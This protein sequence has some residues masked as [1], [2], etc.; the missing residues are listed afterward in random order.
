[1]V[2]CLVFAGTALVARAGAQNA[3]GAPSSPQSDAVNARLQRLKEQADRNPGTRSF[4]YD[5]VQALEEAGREAELLALRPRLDLVSAPATVLAR[6]ARA[7]SSAKQF[8]LA[9]ELFE[10]ALGKAPDR[11]DL[12][13]GLA[14]ALV[15]AGRPADAQARLET[16]P[17]LLQKHVALLDAYAEALRARRE[18]AQALL[19]Y[20]RILVLE[21]AN[22]EAQ[23]NR[24]FT[25]AQLGAPHRAVELAEQSPG[26]LTDAEFAQLRGDRAAVAA[27]WGMAADQNAPARFA[28]TDAALEQNAQLLSATEGAQ[29]RRLQLDR[30]V[31]L[32][33][34]YRMREA[35]DLYD[36]VVAEAGDIPSYVQVAA[37]DACLYLEKPERARDLYKAAIA[38]GSADIG[39]QLGLFYAYNDTEEHQAAMEQIERVVRETPTRVRAYS[40]LTEGDNPDY[41][42]AVATAGAARGYQDRLN[43]AQIQL[44]AFRNQAPWNME[45]RERLAGVY[46]ARGWPRRAELEYQWILAAETRNRAARVGRAHM[47][48]ERRDWRPA[49]SEALALD[50]EY[51]EDRQVQR[52]ATLWRI[53]E[54]REL[55]IEAGTGDSSGSA[56]PLG[57]REH[58]VESWL[59]SSPVRY[60]WRAFL[61]HYDAQATFP[62][63]RG[64]W[65]RIGA[66]A[67][68]RLRDWRA[69]AEVSTGYGGDEGI[70]LTL[71]GDWSM[72]DYWNFEAETE[73]STR[74][75]PLQARNAGVD[76]KSLR[77]GATYRIS[78]SRRFTAG[79][80]AIDFSDGNN[81]EI[82]SATAFQRLYSGPVYKLDT[83]LGLY[84]SRNSLANANYFNPESD[85][86]VDFTLVGEQ[87]L[88]RR[89]DR[90]F[91]HRAYLMLGSYQQTNF[92]TGATGGIRYE[93][94]WSLDDRLTVLY[95]AQRTFHPYDGVREYMNWYNVM[96]NWR[97]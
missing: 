3:P 16:R 54:M 63:G 52:V 47:Q 66:G 80:Q 35:V 51:P 30:V 76:G 73:T 32:R 5:Y 78:E 90:S 94:E 57:S 1:V 65:R 20:D 44:E 43:E 10:A 34:R 60:D 61:H 67:E 45:G 50:L 93:H 88:W 12:L 58:Q 96:L 17:A 79:V 97:F 38:A 8:S 81:R 83:I 69:S 14:Y 72:D 49:Q 62:D 26:L 4:L 2:L 24:I 55:R 95:G 41:A 53:H 13:S 36:E 64:H 70:G 56:G 28:A 37:A 18:Y 15:D 23:R 25:V 77:L 7:A 6:F 42:S 9:V 82:L 75:I 86:G 84:T 19:A 27:R 31:L 71:A 91:V 48:R 21:P 22:R 40:R 29:K 11:I 89:Y 74:A 33:N 68:Y 85:V 92:G 46:S 87:R 39:A 59:Y